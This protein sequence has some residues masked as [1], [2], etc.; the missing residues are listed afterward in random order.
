MT[1]SVTY[2]L[3]PKSDRF[4]VCH[5]HLGHYPTKSLSLARDDKQLIL[6]VPDHLKTPYTQ[7]FVRQN[8]S[9]FCLVHKNYATSYETRGWEAHKLA[10]II[11]IAPVNTRLNFDDAFIC[12]VY[13]CKVVI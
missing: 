8:K 4:T 10:F 3:T 13:L 9:L 12:L 2:I 5:L 7:T 6:L 11:E 1:E